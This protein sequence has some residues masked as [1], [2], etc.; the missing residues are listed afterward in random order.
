MSP[1][2]PIRRWL[3]A[4][5]GWLLV[6]VPTALAVLANPSPLERLDL[7]LYDNLEPLVAPAPAAEPRYQARLQELGARM[8]GAMAVERADADA[9][10]D[11]A[12][13]T[14]L[15]FGAP[16]LLLCHFPKLMKEPQWSDV[17]MWLQTIMLLLRGEGLDSCPQEY[18]GLYGRT[19]KDEL[20]LGDDI[21]LF[22]G[23]AIG[24]RDAANP[25][26][27]FERPRVPLDEQVRFLGF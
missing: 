10:E 1:R 6:I 21:L 2:S 15:A 9:R 7:L 11:F 14:L 4:R 26:N 16:V 24:H 23:L 17:G 27:A 20:G 5:T 12:R 8:Y 18:M 25:V 3:Q 19:I 22:C 13:Q